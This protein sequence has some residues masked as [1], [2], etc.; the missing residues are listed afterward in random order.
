MSLIQANEVSYELHTLGW[1]AFQNLCVTIVSD[2][3]GQTVQV[4]FDSH[5]GGR[6][7]AFQGTW[8]DEKGKLYEGSFTVQCKFTSSSTKIIK[9]SDLSDEVEK[10]K[11]LASKGL[12]HNYFL[13][14]NAKLTGNNE[15]KIKKEFESIPDLN[16]FRAYGNNWITLKIRES[17]KLRML[18]P[19][20]Y[21]LGDLSQIMD[22][23]AYDQANEILASLG[24]E[25]SKFVITNAFRKSAKALMEYGFVILLG[26]PACGKSTISASLALGALDNWRCSTIKIGNPEEFKK[27][28]NP[29]EPKQLFWVDDVFGA[30]QV[31]WRKTFDWNSVFPHLYAAIKKGTKVI[32]TSR[33]YIYKGARGT[34]KE[35]AFPLLKESQIVINVQDLTKNEREQ[36][37]YNHIKLGEQ[38][39]KF[40]RD[41]KKLLPS[42]V[43]NS[44]FSPETARRLGNPLFT[45]SLIFSENEVKNFVDKPMEQLVEIIRTLDVHNRAALALIFM[46]GGMI[47][48]PVEISSDEEKAIKLLLSDAANVRV[49]FSYLEGSMLIRLLENGIYYWKYK[50]PTFRDAFAIIVAEDAELLD[51]YLIG[52]PIN[53]IFSEV[54]CGDVGLEGVKV[55]VPLTRYSQLLERINTLNLSKWHT[56][57]DLVRFLSRRADE[58]FLKGFVDAF[59]EFIERLGITSSMSY[60]SEIDLLV[61]LH[62]CGLIDENK[63]KKLIVEVAHLAVHTPDSGFISGQVRQLITDTE[64][65][66]IISIVKN[67]LLSNLKA[68]IEEW[69]SNYDT[70]SEPEE[71]FD[72]LKSALS[73]FKNEFEGQDDVTSHIDNALSE[74]DI[75]VDYLRTEYYQSWDE[76]EFFEKN[77]SEDAMVTENRSIFE[78]VDK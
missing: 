43:D 61:K 64:Y 11:R 27:H 68:V 77:I 10:A 55:I 72:D 1:K 40:K 42:V 69:E 34:L 41:I 31:D 60:N 57:L 25:L 67:K 20:V 15:E 71:Y 46:R 21:G 19:R 52:A 49:A 37:L 9:L 22:E 7:G 75:S 4:F 6:D 33:D 32:F 78:D 18:V 70:D 44:N 47:E 39:N 2:V 48:S 24:D 62:K 58:K 76:E 53:T 56:K 8:K 16:C 12:A 45:S 3:W 26:E 74:I 5:D 65:E 23:R 63:R 28:W 59:P 29:K 66:E 38:N 36:I 50:H 30:T 17:S 73:G 51:I 13:F 35:A 14:T 54:T